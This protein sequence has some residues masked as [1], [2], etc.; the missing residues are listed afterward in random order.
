[1][2]ERRRPW[3]LARHT[4]I[5]RERRG[6]R[7]GRA[8]FPVGPRTSRL[9]TRRVRGR[10]RPVHHDRERRP[11][12]ACRRLR[13]RTATDEPRF[14]RVSFPSRSASSRSGTRARPRRS[15]FVKSA[16]RPDERLASRAVRSPCG[17]VVDSVPV[18]SRSSH[19]SLRRCEELRDEALR[20]SEI[21]RLPGPGSP[22]RCG[23]D[24]TGEGFMCHPG[25][26]SE[27]GIQRNRS[28]VER[29]GPGR[30]LGALSRPRQCAR[31]SYK[32]RH[33]GFIRSMSASFHARFQC[34]SAFS[35]VIAS[36]IS[37]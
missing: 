25:A 6:R 18:R 37:P 8:S 17:R 30:R 36:V 26:R 9:G 34:L 27:P 2:T 10:L 16:I 20:R 11:R 12:T 14:G 33:S 29:S 1:M 4:R 22:L 21:V 24:D 32:S 35:R 13:N 7:F 19:V 5:R 23:R 28:G 15:S 31:S 3:Q